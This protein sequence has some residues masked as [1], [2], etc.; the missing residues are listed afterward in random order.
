MQEPSVGRIERFA[1]SAQFTLE[2]AQ[3]A[4]SDE[5]RRAYSMYGDYSQMA[6]LVDAHAQ[7]SRS[8]LTGTIELEHQ[9]RTLFS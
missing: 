8:A 9:R 6:A 7:D 5:A 1:S 3:D 2:Q 4:A